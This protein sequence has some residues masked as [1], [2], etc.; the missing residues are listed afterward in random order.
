VYYPPLKIF[1]EAAP[2]PHI[3]SIPGI[4]GASDGVVFSPSS[5]KSLAF[6][7]QRG[8]SYESDKKRIFLTKDVIDGLIAI[9]F[10]ASDDR[11]GSWDS[12]LERIF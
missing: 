1:T 5:S 7:R 12:S 4:E 10:Y 2:E 11:K 8:I 3:I 6:V 9:E